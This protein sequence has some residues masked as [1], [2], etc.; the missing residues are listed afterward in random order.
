[1]GDS[2]DFPAPKLVL[3]EEPVLTVD[4]AVEM[5]TEVSTANCPAFWELLVGLA[6]WARW[7]PRPC[8]LT[9][10]YIVQEAPTPRRPSLCLHLTYP[11]PACPHPTTLSST[12]QGNLLKI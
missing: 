12:A 2:P 4:P 7:Y 5:V 11:R 9:G 1:M 8:K 10:R 6:V 3:S